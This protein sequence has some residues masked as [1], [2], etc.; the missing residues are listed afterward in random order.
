MLSCHSFRMP[1]RP[2][3]PGKSFIMDFEY[4]AEQLQL[5]KSIR[6]FAAAELA[7]HTS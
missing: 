3:Q 7:P 2:G 5:R 4:S 6:D 1:R